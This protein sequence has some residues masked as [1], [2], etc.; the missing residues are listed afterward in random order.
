MRLSKP[1]TFK[2][3]ASQQAAPP[4]APAI[5]AATVAPDQPL[6]SKVSHAIQ[7][8]ESSVTRMAQRQP[9][10]K[11]SFDNLWEEVQEGRKELAQIVKRLQELEGQ[12]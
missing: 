3:A 5:P 1:S 9:H 2:K 7:R 4:Q 6:G 11:Y 12:G 8:L 10:V